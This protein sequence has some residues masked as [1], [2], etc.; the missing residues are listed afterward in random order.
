MATTDYK[1]ML[2]KSAGEKN[3]VEEKEALP[4]AAGQ[5]LIDRSYDY[6]ID[7]RVDLK[8]APSAKSVL[9]KV[10]IMFAVVIVL[11]VMS[12]VML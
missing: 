5:P 3:P 12:R 1:A 4:R 11:C 9:H 6:K 2:E 10:L 7:Q 8:A